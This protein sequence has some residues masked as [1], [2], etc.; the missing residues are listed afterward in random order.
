[1]FLRRLVPW[2]SVDFHV[3]FTEIVPGEPIRRGRETQEG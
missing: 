3:K 2:P 1:M